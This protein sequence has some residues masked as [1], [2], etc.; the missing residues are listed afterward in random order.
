VRSV[1]FAPDGKTLASVGDDMSIILWDAETGQ[2]LKSLD[3]HSAPGWD[4]AF[5]PS[6]T[7]LASASADKTIRLWDVTS[8][9]N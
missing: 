8:S 2:K 7:R 5:H 3:G 6:G 4:L 9:N 1:T